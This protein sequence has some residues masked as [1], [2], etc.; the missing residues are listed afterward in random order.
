MGSTLTLESEKGIGSKFSFELTFDYA[1]K[2]VQSGETKNSQDGDLSGVNILLVEDNKINMLV[3]KKNFNE[4][5]CN[6]HKCL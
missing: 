1:P 2:L 5:Q 3:A 6:S 4:F